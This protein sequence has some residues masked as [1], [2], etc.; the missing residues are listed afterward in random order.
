MAR[1][2]RLQAVPIGIVAYAMVWSLI[3]AALLAA[4]C[5]YGPVLGL[6]AP[7]Q[8]PDAGGSRRCRAPAGRS[9]V[10]QRQVRAEQA[11]VGSAP[12]PSQATF[13]VWNWLIRR[14]AGGRHLLA[15]C[16]CSL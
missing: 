6:H 3:I 4:A 5:A 15:V 8:S 1:G 9:G 12:V 10:A 16:W 11:L 13:D 7:G 2:L 14:R